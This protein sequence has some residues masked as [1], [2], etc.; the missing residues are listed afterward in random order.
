MTTCTRS[1]PAR[2]GW[3]RAEDEAARWVEAARRA[4]EH[5][6]QVYQV[7][8]CGSWIATSGSEPGKAHRLDVT[9]AVCHGCTC[10]G[11]D[12]AKIC[13]HRAAYYLMTGQIAPPPPRRTRRRPSPA[14]APA[15]TLPPTARE[16][17]GIALEPRPDPCPRRWPRLWLV[18]DHAEGGRVVARRQG[19]GEAGV[20]ARKLNGSW[21]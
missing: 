19:S 15:P 2:T 7:E 18:V 3:E 16:R 21:F 8:G 1:A 14:P 5:G 9:G 6:I 4:L 20:V 13:Q 10:A 11:H 17:Y 12:F